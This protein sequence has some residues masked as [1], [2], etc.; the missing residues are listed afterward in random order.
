M[1]LLEQ[2]Q[3][4]LVDAAELGLMLGISR[5]HVSRL[6]K[7][8]KLPKTVRP[9]RRNMRWLAGDIE[10]W[11]SL[12]RPSQEIFERWRGVDDG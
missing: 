2:E 4:N 1:T 9:V 8:G 6:Y 12:G 7:R 5:D 11:L 10:K 3:G